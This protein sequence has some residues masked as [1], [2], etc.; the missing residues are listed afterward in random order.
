MAFIL[1]EL[2]KI[3]KGELAPAYLLYGDDLYLEEEAIDTLSRT[4]TRLAKSIPTEKKI[5]YAADNNDDTF[6]QNLINI[7]LFSVRQIVIYKD[8]PKLTKDYRKPLLQYL[9][10]PQA[11]TL[12]ILTAGGGQSATIFNNVKKHPAV[13]QLSTWSPE[14]EKYPEIIQHALQNRGFTITN[15]ALDALALATDDSLSHA[16]AEIEKICIY[17]EPS[18]EI[19]VDAVRTVIS[20]TKDYQITDFL[21]AIEQRNLYESL[22]ICLALIESG[23]Q[24]TYFIFTLYNFFVNVWAFPQ[25]HRDTHPSYFPARKRR[26]QYERA[27]QNYRDCD[28]GAL[29]ARLQEADLQVKSVSIK[30][31]NLLIPLIYQLLKC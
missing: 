4:F 1:D 13:R 30:T 8:L 22:H 10:H 2:K 24:P 20:G 17:V 9:D 19:T 23:V 16:F 29:F 15:E 12:L 31:E 27:Y 26:S 25:I 21:N 5:Y 3:E 6:M 11:D 28:F 14:A 18:R 7:G